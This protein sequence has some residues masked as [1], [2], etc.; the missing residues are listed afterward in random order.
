[1]DD[2]GALAG[3]FA[4]AAQGEAM[5]RIAAYCDLSAQLAE[6]V[7]EFVRKRASLHA[8]FAKQLA[9]LAANAQ[10]QLAA[11]DPLAQTQLY[12]TWTHTLE[13]TAAEAVS[14]KELASSITNDAT[15]PL[16]TACNLKRILLKELYDDRAFLDDCCKKRQQEVDKARQANETA[17]RTLLAARAANM[18]SGKNPEKTA[19]VEEQALVMK[20][21][22]H[23]EYILTLAAAN[24]ERQKRFE[25]DIPGVLERLQDAQYSS[26]DSAS[27]A[28]QTL[29]GIIGST[30]TSLA[31]QQAQLRDLA[32]QTD[33]AAEVSAWVQAQ[34]FPAFSPPDEI[35]F[36]APPGLTEDSD[37]CWKAYQMIIDGAEVVLGQRVRTLNAEVMELASQIGKETHAVYGIEKLFEQYRSNPSFGS[38]LGILPR[39]YSAQNAVR[40]LR[41]KMC[42]NHAVLH[43]LQN[44]NAEEQDGKLRHTW[45]THT[46]K[47]LTQCDYCHKWMIGLVRQGQHCA[48]CD[49]KVHRSCC[50]FVPVCASK[51]EVKPKA[52]PAA[53]VAQ[54]RSN[55][56]SVRA[57]VL[58][59]EDDE[60]DSDWSSDEEDGDVEDDNIA[61]AVHDY[62]AQSPEE[63]SLK[64]GQIIRHVKAVDQEW[65][66]GTCGDASGQ[67]PSTY[68]RRCDGD[69]A[70]QVLTVFEYTAAND[71]ELSFPCNE[72]ITLVEP[73]RDGWCRGRFHGVTGIFP[74]NFVDMEFIKLDEYVEIGPSETPDGAGQA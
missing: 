52:R 74:A 4:E 58:F 30:Y 32:A 18:A 43:A 66:H 48:S 55:R 11:L 3:T 60:F 22:S 12:Q 38:S 5:P 37:Q 25:T 8:S 70:A 13:T 7:A 36:E 68:A 6:Q 69:L 40:E 44:A 29:S 49:L 51:G 35:G 15:E 2:A 64:S 27:N 28:I 42:Q 17:M 56:S 10:K 16:L 39:L 73:E 54:P 19:V 50:Q 45:R 34:A 26:L 62:A 53:I 59:T 41:T 57:S 67:F 61:V 23:N 24:A 31:D 46:Y 65:W 33:S 9:D 20:R 21:N 71:D 14:H 1:M 72:L 63:L 47:H